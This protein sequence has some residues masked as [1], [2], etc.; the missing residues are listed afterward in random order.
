MNVIF[1]LHAKRA[2][3]NVLEGV[4]SK[5]FRSIR[6]RIQTLFSSLWVMPLNLYLISFPIC[7]HLEGNWLSRTTEYSLY[8]LLFLLYRCII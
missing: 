2:F 8:L 1:F 7:V 5:T 4:N 3:S 6:S